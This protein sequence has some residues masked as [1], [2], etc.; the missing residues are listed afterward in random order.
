MEIL[1]SVKINLHHENQNFLKL[2]KTNRNNKD[3]TCIIHL[4]LYFIQR[5]E[6][7][8]IFVI[9]NTSLITGHG[10]RLYQR[11]VMLLTS[12]CN[13]NL[14]WSQATSAYRHH[15]CTSPESNLFFLQIIEYIEIR[16]T[17]QQ[18]FSLRQKHAHM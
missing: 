17:S 12:S 16:A 14:I 3:S 10:V 15:E 5:D 7:G 18:H 1:Q 6:A 13:C 8:E 2:H 4:V 11:Y 9:S